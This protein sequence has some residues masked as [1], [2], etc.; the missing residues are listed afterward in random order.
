MLLIDSNEFSL[1]SLQQEIEDRLGTN[2]DL[3]ISVKLA[4]VKDFN[5]SN[6]FNKYQMIVYHAVAYKH[7]PLI[8]NPLQGIENNIPQRLQYVRLLKN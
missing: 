6:L 5:L 2:N 1:Y 8:E 4:D 7:V 3:K